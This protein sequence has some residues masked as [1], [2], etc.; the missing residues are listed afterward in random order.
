MN[1]DNLTENVIARQIVAE[2][3]NFGVTQRQI[4]QTIY[5]LSLELED[6][7]KSVAI[8]NIAKENTKNLTTQT[9]LIVDP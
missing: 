1:K 7:E 6:R 8:A 2:V 4:L 3:L 5:L 9:G